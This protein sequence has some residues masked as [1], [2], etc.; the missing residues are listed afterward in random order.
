LT[1]IKNR[2]IKNYA[3]DVLPLRLLRK[4]GTSVNLSDYL[5]ADGA[6]YI[7]WREKDQDQDW[8]RTDN[9][10][11]TDIPNPTDGRINWTTKSVDFKNIQSWIEFEIIG[12]KDLVDQGGGNYQ[13][14][15]GTS[16]INRFPTDFTN[17][18][19]EIYVQE[20]SGAIV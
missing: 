1:Q 14:V 5:L 7:M 12:L 10:T 19:V 15:E 16:K 8:N 17:K 18:F 9:F 2:T 13:F 6:I 3:D 11:T 20:S 4:D